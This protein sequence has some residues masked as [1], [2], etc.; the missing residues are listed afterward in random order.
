MGIGV[1]PQGP[2]RLHQHEPKVDSLIHVDIGHSADT[3]FIFA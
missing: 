1:R 3:V 2:M